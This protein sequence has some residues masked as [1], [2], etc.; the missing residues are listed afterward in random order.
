M[1]VLDLDF[2]FEMFHFIQQGFTCTS[3]N[4]SISAEIQMLNSMSHWITRFP[5]ILGKQRPVYTCDSVVRVMT[6]GLVREVC[7]RG[8]TCIVCSHS[9][10]LEQSRP[11]EIGNIFQLCSYFFFVVFTKKKLN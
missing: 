8:M 10:K 11:S 3:M 6:Y 2:S 7:A 5:R 4:N 1:F 9:N